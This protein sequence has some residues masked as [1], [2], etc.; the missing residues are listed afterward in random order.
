[1]GYNYTQASETIIV[2]LPGYSFEFSVPEESASVAV[3]DGKPRGSGVRPAVI[4]TGEGGVSIQGGSPQR[5][6]VKLTNISSV[7][8]LK[9]LKNVE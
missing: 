7:G 2:T 4:P 6:E 8:S 1:M 9:E 3:K 5:F